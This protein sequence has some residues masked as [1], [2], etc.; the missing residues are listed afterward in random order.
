ME[1]LG[2]DGGHARG[3]RDS[4]A[5][6]NVPEPLRQDGIVGNGLCADEVAAVAGSLRKSEPERGEEHQDEVIR[7]LHLRVSIVSLMTRFSREREREPFME[8]LEVDRSGDDNKQRHTTGSRCPCPRS[9]PRTPASKS[10]ESRYVAHRQC[11]RD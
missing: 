3:R 5:A 8:R 6:E 1:E 9:C 4:V 10:H 2:R 11:G 7:G